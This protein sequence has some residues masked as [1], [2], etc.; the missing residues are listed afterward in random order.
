MLAPVT[1]NYPA[2]YESWLTLKNG[3]QVFL[4][5]IL[6]TDEPLI[7]DL[8][9][10]ISPQSLYLRFLSHPHTLSQEMLYHLT[11]V[12]YDS[13]FALI[14]LIKEDEK[15]AIIAVGRYAR[16]P[17]RDITDLAVAVRDDW[18]HVGLGKALLV[19]TVDIAKAH[20]ISHFESMMD[21]QNHTM[22]RILSELGYKVEYSLQGGFFQVEIIV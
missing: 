14:A 21:P 8:F 13:Q 4:R 20:G 18:Q 7:V 3:R 2:Q 17:H 15:D 1:E 16:D 22:K 10:R 11:H 12:D 9:N 19:N 5:P 6:Q